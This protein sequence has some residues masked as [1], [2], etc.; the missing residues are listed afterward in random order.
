[1]KLSILSALGFL[2]LFHQD[3]AAGVSHSTFGKTADGEE[4]EIYTLTNKAGM[5]VTVLTYGGIVASIRTPD[6]QGHFDDVALGFEKL[7]GYLGTHPYFGALIGRY[8]NR[9]GGAQFTLNDHLYKLKANDNGNTLHGGIKGFDKRIWKASS[10]TKS[11]VTL[12]YTSDNG[13]EGFPGTLKVS[14]MYTLT[15]DNE[16]RIHYFATTDK[17]TVL[18]LTNHSYFNL[19]G[20]G[21]G[22][23]LKHEVTI[24]ADQF[25]PVDQTLIPTGELRPVKDTPFDFLKPVAIGARI[26]KDDEQIKFGG[27][28]DHNFVLNKKGSGPEKVAEVYEPTS[29]RVMEVFTSEP[30]LQFYTGNFLDGSITG[31]SGKVYQKRYA[32][33]METQHFPDS[34]NKPSFPSVVLKPGARYRTTTV[35]K[36]ST[37]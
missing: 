9:I 37:R 8:G 29:G 24:N 35:Y 6:K 31:K 20:A 21:N 22:D 33:C 30:G 34:P 2:L 11:S 5:E 18:N 13:E 16:L 27:G 14:V 10:S 15:E 7:D 32:F 1:M 4:I 19:A 3:S 12:R 36:F 25:T 17:P 23:V 28:Y 26:D